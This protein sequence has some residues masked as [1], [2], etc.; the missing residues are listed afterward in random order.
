MSSKARTADGWRVCPASRVSRK[1]RR[2]AAL[3]I[4]IA[5]MTILLAIALTYFTVARQESRVA[6]NVSNQV[7][8]DLLSDAAIAIAVAQLNQ[9]VLR[10]P[11]A[12]S[13]DHAWR[14]TFNGAWLQGKTWALQ[15]DVNGNPIP[16]EAGGIP[17]INL[18]TMP[19]IEFSD[20]WREALYRGPRT[21]QWLYI[22]RAEGAVHFIYARYG[23]YALYD[24]ADGDELNVNTTDLSMTDSYG[25]RF[26]PLAFTSDGAVDRSGTYPGYYAPFVTSAIHSTVDGGAAAGYPAEQ[27][28]AWT[29]VDNDGDG[30]PDSMWI[31]IPIDAILTLDHYADLWGIDN[32]LDGLVGGFDVY[33]T[34]NFISEP[35][36][37]DDDPN[38]AGPF[39]YWGGADGL[40]NDGD[41]LVDQGDTAQ[42]S[43]NATV[44]YDARFGDPAL[45][46]STL[47]TD[48][49]NFGF[50]LTA[51][52]PGLRIP[53]DAD[54]DGTPGN[55]DL[56]ADGY[57]DQMVV[58]VPRNI[59][60]NFISRSGGHYVTLR[61]TADYV[62]T[63]DNDYDLIANDYFTYAYLDTEV[64]SVP[65]FA[66]SDIAIGAAE[67]G[68]PY[69]IEREDLYIESESQPQIDHLTRQEYNALINGYRAG[70]RITHSGEPV[71]ELAGRAAVLIND[72]ASKVNINS[73]G[74]HEFYDDA[75]RYPNNLFSS[76]TDFA[77]V[78]DNV[79]QRSLADG[80][81]TYEYDTRTLPGVGTQGAQNLWA[82]L[83]G[84]PDTDPTN[85]DNALLAPYRWDAFLP[86]YGRADDNGNAF[87]AC[88]N[89][90]DDDGDGLVDEGLYLPPL[91]FWTY[92]YVNDSADFQSLDTDEQNAVRNAALLELNETKFVQYF[93]RLGLFE[94]VDE[95]GELQR[96]R[97]VRNLLA[98][99]DHEG[100]NPDNP[101]LDNDADGVANEFGE[102][103]DRQFQNRE[104]LAAAYQLGTAGV[105]RLLPYVTTHST[106]RNV[107]YV[108]TDVGLSAINRLDLNHAPAQQIAASLMIEGEFTPIT[109][110]GVSRPGTSV[111][112]N[113]ET[114]EFAQGLRQGDMNLVTPPVGNDLPDLGGGFLHAYD[115]DADVVYPTSVVLP[116][117]PQLQVMQMAVD[118]VDAR[119]SGYG[120]TTLT[121]E[122]ADLLADDV[123][124]TGSIP[125]PWPLPSDLNMREA[126]PEE[127]LMPLEEVQEYIKKTLE[128]GAADSGEKRL[129]STDD[130]WA[131]FTTH[132]ETDSDGALVDVHEE[133]H[134][135]YT[136]TGA[137]A[138]RINELMVR[139]VRRVEAEMQAG[140]DTMLDPAPAI[141]GI[142]G[143]LPEFKLAKRSYNEADGYAIHGLTPL[144]QTVEPWTLYTTLTTAVLG[145]QSGV[146]KPVETG[147]GTS[148][149]V[150]EVCEDVACAVKSAVTIPEA[151]QFLFVETGGLP[152][153][154]YYLTADVLVDGAAPEPP[155][156][157]ATEYVPPLQY[158]IKYVYKNPDLVAQTDWES[159]IIDDLALLI[160][161]VNTTNTVGYLSED[162]LDTGAAGVI[163]D[164]GQ[165]NWQYPPLTHIASRYGETPGRVFLDGTPKANP[166]LD[167]ST[168]PT[169]KSPPS[170]GYFSEFPFAVSFALD[171]TQ[172]ADGTGQA[173]AVAEGRVWLEDRFF[174]DVLVNS[175]GAAGTDGLDDLYFDTL[176][177]ELDPGTVTNPSAFEL[178][179]GAAGVVGVQLYTP[180]TPVPEDALA[181]DLS[182]LAD[183]VS[184]VNAILDGLLYVRIGGSVGTV[185]GQVYENAAAAAPHRPTHTVTVPPADSGYV[186]CVGIVNPEPARELVVNFFE[187]SQEPDH[188]YVELVNVSDEPVNVSG[189]ELE[190]GIPDRPGVQPD[191]F[192]SLW[193]VPGKTVVAPHGMLLLSFDGNRDGT[194]DSKFDRY[195]APLGQAN[196][197][198]FNV[199]GIG[200]AAGGQYGGDSVTNFVDIT[201]ITVPPVYDV[202]PAFDSTQIFSGPGVL[203]LEDWVGTG[204]LYDPTGSVFA[205]PYA[206]NTTT[207]YNYYRDYV[208]SNGDGL[209]S[210]H[211]AIVNRAGLLDAGNPNLNI[212]KR[213]LEALDAIDSDGAAIE[214]DY[215][216][217]VGANTSSGSKPWDRIVALRCKRLE[218]DPNVS[219][220]GAGAEGRTLYQVEDVDAVARMV[221]RGG[222]LPNYPEHDGIDN[223]GDASYYTTDGLRVR[224]VLAKDMVDNDLD[225]LIDEDSIQTFAPIIT[226]ENPLL[227]EGVDEGARLF[228]RKWGAGSY[229]PGVLPIRFYD[230][231]N[232]HVDRLYELDRTDLS[233]TPATA[234]LQD[235]LNSSGDP[236]AILPYGV[237]DTGD[238]SYAY[239][240]QV[241]PAYAGSDASI[242]TLG[243]NPEGADYSLWGLD[244]P[245]IAPY[246]GS[247]VDP[248]DWKVFAER[249]WYPGDNVIVTLYEGPASAGSVA[250]RV[251]YREL[252]VTNR[253][254]DDIVPNPYYED[255][256]GEAGFESGTDNWLGLNVYYP[257]LWAPD[258]MGLDFYRAL[259]RKHPLYNGDRFGTE[260]R[261]QATDGNYDDWADSLSWFE[262]WLVVDDSTSPWTRIT[263]ADSDD[264]SIPFT[265][266]RLGET[267]DLGKRYN[268][269]LFGHAMYGSPLRMNTAQRLSE[270][271]PDLFKALDID[272]DLGY[273]DPAFNRRRNDQFPGL[274]DN[275]D[276]SHAKAAIRNRPFE[277]AGELMELPH[278]VLS[279]TMVNLAD[280]ESNALFRHVLDPAQLN[281]PFIWPS[282][283]EPVVTPQDTLF[284]YEAALLGQDELDDE[285]RGNLLTHAVD[286]TALENTVLTVAQADFTPISGMPAHSNVAPGFDPDWLLWDPNGNEDAVL[287]APAAWTPVFLFTLA[288]DDVT[289]LYP[290]FPDGSGGVD[291]FDAVPLFNVDYQGNAFGASVNPFFG[292]LYTDEMAARWP[293]SKRAIMYIA[294][295][296]ANAAPAEALF[297]WDGADGLENGEYILYIGTYTP[298]LAKRVDTARDAIAE[299]AQQELVD[300]GAL[301]IQPDEDLTYADHRTESL[302]DMDPA[303]SGV[304]SRRFDPHLAVQVITDPAAASGIVWPVDDPSWDSAVERRNSVGLAHPDSWYTDATSALP[305][306]SDGYIFYGNSLWQPIPVQ[307]RDNFLALR[308]RNLGAAGQV[309]VVSH[310]VLAPRKRVPGRINVNT[311]ADQTR[312][313]DDDYKELWN[314]LLGLPALVNVPEE[315]EPPADLNAYGID[316]DDLPGPAL[317]YTADLGLLDAASP[318]DGGYRPRPGRDPDYDS[319]V[320]PSFMANWP[321]PLRR[322]VDRV[323]F[324]MIGGEGGANQDVVAPDYLL[325][326]E[327][328]NLLTQPNGLSLDNY[329]ELR[330]QYAAQRLSYLM[331]YGRTEHA[332]GRYYEK[333]SD[334]ARDASGFVPPQVQAE[335]YDEGNTNL[336]DHAQDLAVY[337]LSNEGDRERRFEEVLERF[338]RMSNL[339]TTRSD[340]FEIIVTVQAGYGVDLNGD[341]RYNYRSPD[342]FVVTAE[343]KTRL[344][345]ERRS[346]SDQS[347]RPRE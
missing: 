251:T 323:G 68:R 272:L 228:W 157:S 333:I 26:V 169:L 199:N 347:G 92:A 107:A 249:R 72:E 320:V 102:M 322:D 227:C 47:P 121:T 235:W 345:Y 243:F 229:E 162:G 49:T 12:T 71:C 302:L 218:L 273:S 81:G 341:G 212:L 9:D 179:I 52:L 130:W 317:S 133:R 190:I 148:G 292:G 312:Q 224:G 207:G 167:L 160:N 186:L 55:E 150:Y 321:V 221:L 151:V 286:M 99:N 40:D 117:D 139:P 116:A 196:V 61:M 42:T 183:P 339:V 38:E 122:R 181:F 146:A 131:S 103:G 155:G 295:A 82:V 233:V 185:R 128:I 270:N 60:V 120:R 262:N 180:V 200:L 135:S 329:R 79:I 142:D 69:V 88:F 46:P 197:N 187:F 13:L 241:I 23:T 237:Y 193:E 204:M 7:R 85:F 245:E 106:D 59:F 96:F 5:I 164:F 123:P 287:Q 250:D 127:E 115:A 220:W 325:Y 3:V 289:P 303:L 338:R 37:E 327:E 101:A 267:T 171:A 217:T 89:G 268:S 29:D 297:S 95:P 280:V 258:Q 1:G 275:L 152:A 73:A 4:V 175:T 41:G 346:P 202:S 232:T 191:P 87:L 76:G 279:H 159:D 90:R 177:V 214:D 219:P 111:T 182:A 254:V 83:M 239:G 216:A 20:G 260:N 344:V 332:D 43:P 247:D 19:D 184:A 137:E 14:A 281:L 304:G 64:S 84:A 299:V 119:D 283:T 240:V 342:E 311:V 50:F 126:I 215:L 296:D 284:T 163:R 261:W 36:G 109:E 201:D 222:V 16:L 276:W 125:A 244:E 62:D 293:L 274:E 188:E 210:A 58:R 271:P 256:D 70:I 301:A 134:I 326:G 307:V 149:F 154:R 264:P 310:V 45:I 231:R 51:P 328:D 114:L 213:E 165:T 91:T 330:R 206:E 316:Y 226:T 308:V 156:A 242:R 298:D 336:R 129:E 6:T 282:A 22:P 337:P 113:T 144:D 77:A 28:A 259:E 33:D 31:P 306:G 315:M 174:A 263:R 132:E 198:K 205:R 288:E 340:V 230:D 203:G 124:L 294:E 18:N 97:P 80:A 305:V 334:L 110:R 140:T 15:R 170:R 141:L 112:S 21:R 234:V 100:D 86:G 208:D 75:I 104:Q 335:Y 223:D 8:G 48:G 66:Y 252:D 93:N 173:G 176:V 194:A 168:D 257:S 44:E 253:T 2:G 324:A 172:V 248:L 236:N 25:Q 291:A 147:G 266:A 57:D 10:H 238:G 136:T 209:S 300:A 290:T 30:L 27:V 56:N 178:R 343:N 318:S 39:V 314:A 195:R 265:T 108:E 166:S 35:D 331:T 319:G 285:N 11:G 255:L 118:M 143:V 74:G 78:V 65:R 17:S 225:G 277:S 192:K 94:G 278:F 189:W 211:Y 269:R 53:I 313:K 67:E 54:G 24:A 145:N 161:E 105:D 309:A 98:E 34:T 158:S 63:I 138:I 246:L 32:D 153:G